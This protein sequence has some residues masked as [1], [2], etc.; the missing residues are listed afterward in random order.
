MTT[1][2][3]KLSKRFVNFSIALILLKENSAICNVLGQRGVI[4]EHGHQRL[5]LEEK[6]SPKVT[7]VVLSH[8]HRP[9][10]VTPCGVPPSNCSGMLTTGKY[11]DFDSLRGAPPQGEGFSGG[12]I[13]EKNTY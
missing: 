12:N 2:N 7:D 1:T 10:S 8:C 13:A 3:A 6:L 5:L 4:T 9:T 11:A